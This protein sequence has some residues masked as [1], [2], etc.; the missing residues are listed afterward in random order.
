M[1]LPN[2]LPDNPTRWDGW[3]YYDSADYY[4]RLCLS[5]DSNPSAEQIEDNCRQLLVWWQKKLP[6][7]N[8]PSNP[9]SQMLRGGMDEA[10][11][12]LAEARTVLL[13]P[14]ARAKLDHELHER[15]IQ[16]ALEEFK[17]LLA[18]AISENQLRD[19]EEQRLYER[20]RGLGLGRE[21]MQAAVDAELARMGAERIG[22][23][24]VAPT[25]NTGTPAA[26]EREIGDP[27]SEFRRLMRM[28]RLCLEGEDMTDDQRDAMCNLGESLG[29]TGGQAEDLID[30]YLEEV[31][32]LPISAPNLSPTRGAAA[33]ATAPKPAMPQRPAPLPAAKKPEPAVAT[34]AP[35]LLP[36]P[37]GR[38][39][40][41]VKFPNF[42]N[43][44]GMEMQLVTSGVFVMGSNAREAQPNEQPLTKV[45]ITCLYV[46][47]F[48]VTN[49]Q[50]EL[51]DPAHKNKRAPWADGNHPVVYVSSRDAEKFCQW[52]SAKDGR[53]Y[54]LPTEA[55]WEYAARG[56]D[57]RTF[58]WGERLDNGLYANFADAKTTF[59]WRDQTIDDGFAETSPVGSFP[60][61]ASPF[62]IE[63]LAGNVF[64]WCLDCFENYKGKDRV[65]P[66][67]MT[68][69]AKRNY[70]GGSWK[71]RSV[72][73]R[74]T[75]RA[76]NQPDYL[77]N[78]VGF[79]VVCE[80]VTT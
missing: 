41:R 21:E 11:K 16:T 56:L 28:S 39:Q 73:L 30:E 48:P 13:D 9:L 43:A 79:R 23:T 80:C 45:T 7:K 49:A 54:R 22:V 25:L 17:K 53:K 66:R 40:E 51:F 72:S 71:S 12:F 52:L 63:D 62:G 61:G 70:R 14:E 34:K 26:M 32:G 47:R 65:D 18:F 55:E 15:A 44:G 77:S 1:A 10:P 42:T 2:P 29:L 57:G 37:L 36:S 5:F 27:F 59:A 24:I 68:Q 20:G 33:V 78:D 35:V 3:K 4:A 38:A 31:S 75:A 64:E 6:L 46:A 58:P 8:Q 60:K 69:G 74:T 67:G 50:F 19:I 76:F